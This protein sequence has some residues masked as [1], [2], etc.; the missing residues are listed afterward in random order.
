MS[1]DNASPRDTIF[2]LSSG[3]P[4]AAIAVVRIS[5]PQAGA[6]LR[7]LATLPAP[8]RAT[9][10]TLRDPDTAEILDNGLVLWMPGPASV[11]GEDVVELH[12][13]GGRAVVGG[14]LSALG[15]LAGHR[16]AEPGEFTRRAFDN[17]RI[18]LNEA[19]GL[20]DLLAAETDGQRRAAL[21]AAGGAFSR[22]VETWRARLL[23]MAASAEAAIDYSEEI[24]DEASTQSVSGEADRLASDIGVALAAPPAERLKEG[25]RVVF[26]GPPNVGKSTLI[27]VLAGRDAAITSEIAGTTRDVIEVPVVI[28]GLPIIMIDTAG[29]RETGDAVEQEGIA[30]ARREVAG[31]DIV[32]WLGAEPP[33]CHDQLIA[34]L[35]QADRWPVDPDLL[36]VSAETGFN[37]QVLTRNIV[38]RARTLLPP[39]GTM[40]LNVRQRALAEQLQSCLRAAGAASD[41]VIQAEELRSGLAVCNR[42][43]GRSGVEDMLNTLFGSLC[44]GK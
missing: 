36:A 40:A 34:I 16:Q 7:R 41:V 18:D 38:E 11:T 43:A 14:V 26:A 22:Q 5:G 2:A 3:R 17:G 27:N 42:L 1:R 25:I 19:E 9:S 33:P 32:I 21:L 39:E 12:L 35:P 31:G 28:E 13:H 20:A 10:A 23:A 44:L 4:P 37:L 15:R 30:R 29:V 24:G 6:G 8:R